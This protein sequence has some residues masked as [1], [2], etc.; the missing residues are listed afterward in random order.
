MTKNVIILSHLYTTVPV[1][2]LEEYFL[3]KKVENLLFIAHPLFYQKDRPGAFFSL[4]HKGKII[5]QGSLPQVYLPSILQYLK[6]TLLTLYWVILT[7]RK[8]DLIVSLDNLNTIAAILLRKIGKVK[9]VIYYTIDFVPV[10]FQNTLLNDVYHYLDQVCLTHAD[11]TWNVSPRIA[12][13]REKVRGLLQSVYNKQITVPIGIWFDRIARKKFSE[14][15]KHVIVY[16]GGLAEHQGVQ[17]VLDALPQIVAKIP[18]IKFKIIGI[19]NYEATLK[20]KV[21]KLKLS[22][23]VEFLGYKETHQEVE[24][25]LSSCGLAMA[26]Y[27]EKLDKWSYYADPSKIKT[28]LAAGL[29]VLTTSL[30][31]IAKDL[32]SHHC[33]K[34]I[35]YN[36]DDLATAVCTLLSNPR[37]H[38]E[39]RKNA[40]NFA[41]EFDW[42]SVFDRALKT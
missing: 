27:S 8:W 26:M 36:K 33:G 28:Y 39:M 11:S 1:R 5:K 19:G 6:D 41:K 15:E 4:Y 31:H 3:H 14:I 42:N 30:T 18:D 24:E 35:A 16:A 40:V 29:P 38:S 10:R 9:K 2:D 34:V 20:Q 23:Y 32:A 21:K 12:E 25:I 17:L 7:G 37:Q 13:G 22:K